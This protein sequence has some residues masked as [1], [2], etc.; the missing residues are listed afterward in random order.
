MEAVSLALSRLEG[1]LQT[2]VHTQFDTL[3]N[4]N[5]GLRVI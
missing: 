2:V 4:G 1:D 5:A 3:P